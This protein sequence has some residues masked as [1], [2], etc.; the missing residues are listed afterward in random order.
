MNNLRFALRV[1]I[2]IA[3]KADNENKKLYLLYKKLKT[4]TKTKA[5]LD[6]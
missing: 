4:K 1:V 5:K 6:F 2:L 3:F